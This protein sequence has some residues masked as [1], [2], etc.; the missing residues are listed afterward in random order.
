MQAKNCKTRS[1]LV[2]SETSPF[3]DTLI[4]CFRLSSVKT[5]TPLDS[6][7]SDSSAYATLHYI[8]KKETLEKSL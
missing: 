3:L 7:S 4:F 8:N 2:L 1:T 6:N 5:L